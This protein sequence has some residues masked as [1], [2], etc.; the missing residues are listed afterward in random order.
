MAKRQ[1]R[2]RAM[3]AVAVLFLLTLGGVPLTQA[4]L[5][6]RNA[7]ADGG[8]LWPASLDPRPLGWWPSVDDLR[9]F[10]ESLESESFLRDT[11]VPL[12]QLPLVE[13]GAGNEQVYLGRDGWLFYSEDVHHVTGP[14]FLAKDRGPAD[15]GPVRALVDLQRQLRDRGADLLVVPVPVK[16]TIHPEK[17]SRRFRASDAPVHNASFSDFLEELSREGVP[18]LDLAPAFVAWKSPER[19]LYLATDTHW[20]PETVRVAA[21][22]IAGWIRRTHPDL[23]AG[24]PGGEPP[25]V[26][27]VALGDT[28]RML[29]L[30]AEQRLYPPEAAILRPV[31]PA[32]SE[33][34]PI[35]LL[36]DSFSNMFS[37]QTMGW[38][39]HAGL[40]DHLARELGRPV[41]TIAL[42]DGGALAIRAALAR[43][44]AREPELLAVTRLV[45]YQFAARELSLGD[46]RA[47]E[48]PPPG[49]P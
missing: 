3:A 24:G 41:E 10:E 14:P 46:W 19:P 25:K 6:V 37:L 49:L 29:K 44:A 47:V 39:R 42:N 43:R 1:D 38:G 22:E 8:V 2:Q 48:L 35:L 26:R 23:D 28:A 12:V 21:S 20:T 7:L 11:V 27:V 5:E 32:A 40:A 31:E 36:G 34:G 13:L 18:A 4:V 9:G 17:L 16:P 45:I 33:N 30:P 15:L